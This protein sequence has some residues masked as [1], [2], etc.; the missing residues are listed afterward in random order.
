MRS[1]DV[2][3]AIVT[4]VE[5]NLRAFTERE[6]ERARAARELMVRMGFPSAAMAMSIV[7]SGSNFDISSR[8]F[9]VAEAIW[10][11]HMASLKGKTMK[12]AS[13]VLDIMIKAKIVQKE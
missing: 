12:R 4:T 2:E 13:V 3:T 1:I 10:G 6:I 8:D 5:Q 11:R 9:R 7:N